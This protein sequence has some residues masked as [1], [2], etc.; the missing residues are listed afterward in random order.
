MSSPVIIIFW[1]P[2]LAEEVLASL[3]VFSWEIPPDGLFP[4]LFCAPLGVIFD[5]T[6]GDFLSRMLSDYI[7]SFPRADDVRSFLGFD[8]A[9]NVERILVRPGSFSSLADPKSLY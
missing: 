2:P 3:E 7:V 6:L 4:V 9:A 8:S 1:F 5:Y